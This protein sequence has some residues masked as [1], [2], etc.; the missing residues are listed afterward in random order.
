MN[1]LIE[2]FVLA[3]CSPW[4]SVALAFLMSLMFGVALLAR[5]SG[6]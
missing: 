5:Y 1:R 6:E 4:T 3:M 2:T